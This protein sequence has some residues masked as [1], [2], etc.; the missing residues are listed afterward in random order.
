MA[1][2]TIKFDIK[3]AVDTGGLD[4]FVSQ[5]RQL[6]DVAEPADRVLGQAVREIKA[7]ADG[8]RASE[9]NTSAATTAIRALAGAMTAGGTE[10]RKATQAGNDLNK[11][12]R[13]TVNAATAAKAALAAPARTTMGASQQIVDMRKGL[14][15]LTIGSTQYLNLLQQITEKEALLGRRTGRAGVV[16]ANQAFEGALL[17]RGYGSADRLQEMPNTTAALKQR[18]SELSQEFPNVIRGSSD[19]LRIARE[20]SAI[21]RELAKDLTGTTQAIRQRSSATQAKIDAVRAYNEQSIRDRVAAGD[22]SVA[23]RRR[24]AFGDVPQAMRTESGTFIA[25]P[26]QSSGYAGMGTMYPKP[27]GPQ[28]ALDYFGAIKSQYSKPLGP[29]TPLEFWGSRISSGAMQGPAAPSELFRS[30]GGIDT[31]GTTARL[32]TM[33]RSYEQVA[34][35]IRE[36]AQ[37]AGGSTRALQAERQAWE[38]L[39]ASVGPATREYKQ[40]GREIQRL[41]RQLGSGTRGQRF[42]ESAGAISAGA[43]FGGPEGLIGGVLGAASGVPGGAL[44]G[45]AAGAQLGIVRKAIGDASTYSAE[46]E[47]LRIALRGVVGDNAD[48]AKSLEIVN[49]ASSRL[50]IQQEDALRGFTRLSASVLAA[51]GNVEDAKI[52]FEGVNTAIKAT[53][54]SSSEAQAA[55][56]ALSQVFSKGKVSAEE[57]SGQLGERLAGAVALFA[58]ATGRT[59]PQLNKDLKDGIVGLADVIKFTSALGDKYAATANQISRSTEDAGAR[60]AVALGKFR[61]AIGNTF[62]P[63]GALL[64]DN[65]SKVLDWASSWINNINNVIKAYQRLQRLQGPAFSNGES[66]NERATRTIENLKNNSPNFNNRSFWKVDPTGIFNYTDTVFA[67]RR[68]RGSAVDVRNQIEK[69]LL[70]QQFPTETTPASSNRPSNLPIANGSDPETE[71]RKRERDEQRR[72]N[73]AAQKQ[74]LDLQNY[75]D[76]VRLDEQRAENVIRLEN[77]IFEHKQELMRREREQM[78]QLDQLRQQTL[79]TSLSPEGRAAAG[80]IEELRQRLQGIGQER[81]SLQD[82]LAAARQD[83]TSARKRAENAQLFGSMYRTE[84]G[85]GSTTVGGGASGRIIQ[86]FHGDPARPG[87]DPKGHGS[88]TNAHDHYAFDT[89]KTTRMVMSALRQLGYTV[90]EFGVKSGH[91]NGSLHYSNQAFDVPWAQFGSGPIGQRDFKR[92]RKL[93][94]DIERIL[95]MSGGGTA[96]TTTTLANGNEIRTPGA[97]AAALRSAGSAGD[98]EGALANLQSIQDQIKQFDQYAPKIASQAVSLS[99]AQLTQ[100]LDDQKIALQDNYEEW[101]LRNR[102]QLENVK[103]ELIDFEVSKTKALRE[104]ERAVRDL[105]KRLEEARPELE[106]AFKAKGSK[107]PALEY[108]NLVDQITG[109]IEQRTATNIAIQREMAQAAVDP[110]LEWQRKMNA[111]GQ[112]TRDFND[113]LKLGMSLSDQFT[114]NLANGFSTAASAIVTGNGSIQQSFAD[115]FNNI[116]K[117]FLDTIARVLADQLTMQFLKL[118]QPATGFNQYTSIIGGLISSFGSGIGGNLGGSGF[119]DLGGSVA[120]NF[121][122]GLPQLA[123]SGITGTMLSGF[124]TGGISAGPTSGYPVM[125][126]GTEAVIPL[127]NGRAVPVEM[128][129]SGGTSV[130]VNVNMSTGESSVSSNERDGQLLGK[131][132]SEAVQA[133]LIRQKRPGGILYA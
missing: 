27:I 16:A 28:T 89:E 5:L 59:L 88:P 131:A 1:N 118:L 72:L 113:T 42:V 109:G 26:F 41:D 105:T 122:P 23:E 92:S 103:P 14:Q 120:G 132:L 31:A 47:K 107:D 96:P 40:A 20:M 111:L 57:L 84:D 68:L 83:L 58:K 64:Q 98:V 76:R 12:L 18:L 95:G 115:L 4:E 91:T 125:L 108:R 127:P 15:E 106:K 81:Q 39:Q 101:K 94:A 100:S 80:P 123:P 67:G 129:G 104:Q 130:V 60:Q 114:G 82:Q 116:A 110:Y 30:I 7:W 69:I 50:N 126:H 73:E 22:M 133:E 37:A 102:L 87:Y 112:S 78:L 121:A 21:E 124:A 32:Q 49:G 119:G 38:Q 48:Y 53:G 36:T 19:Y 17:S 35:Q 6:K 55:L 10:W 85:G 25:P 43:F 63:L 33:G 97:A 66:I 51:G 45:A 2:N 86:H 99:I 79:I 24:T 70:E 46:L 8:A 75:N 34:Q 52:V 62:E 74:R 93:R 56:L 77:R 3:A 13:E 29:Q 61:E 65:S 54:G 11:T 117:M 9:R 71:R 90:T 128:K 44:A